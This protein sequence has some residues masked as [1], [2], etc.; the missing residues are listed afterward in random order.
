VDAKAFLSVIDGS[1]NRR[2]S[3]AIS[4]VAETL[5]K[6]HRVSWLVGAVVGALQ[7][8]HPTCRNSR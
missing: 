1:A 5:R 3:A 4:G 8:I 6:S 2:L 7:S